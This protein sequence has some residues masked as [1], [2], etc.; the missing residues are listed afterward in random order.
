MSSLL[1]IIVPFVLFFVLGLLG[2]NLKS[3]ISGII[4]TGGMSICTFTAYVMAYQYFFRI[5]KKGEGV[6]KE[7]VPLDFQWLHFMGGMHI[8]LG[9]LL[10][11]I[12]VMMLV[13]IT[14]VSLM[15][16]IYSLGYMKGEIGF[17]RYYA[18]LSL[19]SFSMLG[20]V[21][22]TNIFQM[23][24]FWE[25]VGVSS[26]LLI[27]FYYIKPSAVAA[28]KKAFIVTRFADL[29]FLIG[30]LILSYYTRTFDFR[31]LTANN[32]VLVTASTAG[33][34]FLGLSV[35]VWA[36]ALIFMGGAGKSAMFPLHIWLPDAME[37]PT[38][39]SALIHAA[40]MVV[41][42]VYLITRLFPVYF[43]AA[44]SVL[45][46]IAFV[47]AFTSF[48]TA[49]IAVVQTDIKRV[50][51]FS[52]ISQISYMMAALGVSKY[53]GYEGLG[54]TASMFHL[55]THA[56]FKALLFL[57]AGSVIHVVNSNEM[58]NM[59]GLHKY[60]P[61]TNITFLIACLAIAGIPPFSGFYSKDE[62]LVATLHY[63]PII[64]WILWVV[65]GLTA[66]YMFRLYFCIF[67][68]GEKKYDIYHAS[69]ESPFLMIFPLVIL[70]VFS[71][72][73]GLI[74]FANFVSSDNISLH[75]HI[76]W[77]VA[78]MS[79]MIAVFGIGI[80]AFLYLKDSGRPAKIAQ[81]CGVLYKLIL[82]KFYW[83]EIWMWMTK[84]V[85]F[86]FICESVKWFDRHI[87]DWSMNGLAWTIQRFS[88]SVKGL[89][90]GHVQF[91]M[92]IFISGLTLITIWVFFL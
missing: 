73:G 46:M 47:G 9:V 65:A 75:T 8:N 10:D 48:F 39:V 62:V 77:T 59:C 83:D 52:T 2:T 57:G 45:K 92:W 13:V 32:A 90:S 89:Q 69:H 71:V 84:R 17:Q 76:N 33:R 7:I 43:F 79:V 37:G 21:V 49:I 85:I 30:I 60:M 23:Y 56:F 70:S 78:S 72:F 29:G 12:S 27:G 18:F 3:N 14:T 66:F 25:L 86:Q 82:H 54:Y 68:N 67:W 1:I 88:L 19:F 6:W 44:P 5:G 50:L 35:S 74:P 64:F 63:Q 40:T 34:T 20:L 41:A 81:F 36:L 4:G 55:F 58:N 24:I 22:A 51:A 16:H 53:G 11:P 42:G 91:Y 31:A 61:I 80:A 15:V 38:P 26:Y 28:S 87:I